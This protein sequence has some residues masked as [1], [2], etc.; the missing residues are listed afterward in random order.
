MRRRAALLA[1]LACPAAWAQGGSEPSTAERLLFVEPHLKDLSAP[2][3]LRYRFTHRQ[4]SPAD[5]SF[6]DEVTLLLEP[7]AGGRC[8]AVQGRFLSGAREIRLP[9][10]DDAQA[11]PVTMY[12]LE[13]EVRELQRVTGGQA[14]H[15]RRRIRLALAH[16]GPPQAA[17]VLHGGR[18]LAGQEIEIAPYE[19]DPMRGRFERQA[20]TRYRFVLSS[21]VPGG[22]WLIES[23]LAG[24]R[25]DTLTFVE[26]SR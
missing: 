2:L 13:R 6:D 26:T 5:A 4:T 11:N 21:R 23:R 20:P 16:A 10:I 19:D 12:F 24:E 9:P 8:C 22:I 14:A 17:T 18:E 25:T 7:R 1:L 3:R 15:F